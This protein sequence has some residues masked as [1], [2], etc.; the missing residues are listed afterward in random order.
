MATSIQNPSNTNIIVNEW[1]NVYNAGPVAGFT[2]T[3]RIVVEVGNGTTIKLNNNAT[4]VTAITQGYGNLYDGNATSIAFEGTLEQVNTALQSLQALNNNAAVSSTLQISAVKAGSAYNPANGHY[5]QVIDS[6]GGMSWL[7]AKTAAASDSLK[8]NGLTGYLA[9]ITSAQENEFILNKL[10]ADA[11]IGATDKDTEGRWKWDTGPEA[12]QEFWYWDDLN[13]KGVTVDGRYH[14]W[15]SN[16]PN[17]STSHTGSPEGEDYGQFYVSG[18]SPGKWND[19]PGAGATAGKLNYYVVEYGGMIGDNPTEAAASSSS[20]LTV[21]ARPVITSNGG[22]ATASINYA[23][24]GSTAV[25]TVTATDADNGDS[26]TYSITG[27]TDAALFNIENST[28]ALTFKTSPDYEGE[29]ENSY[30][31]TVRVTDST[32]LY[33]EQTL[34]V[35]VTDVNDHAPVFTSGVTGSVAENAAISTVIYDAATTDA[36]GTTT[37][38]NVVYSLKS[39]QGDDASLLDI[40]ST[41]GEVSLKTSA[42][43]E[44]KNSYAFT[45]VATNAGTGATLVTEQ[46]VS[47]SVSDVNDLPVITAGTNT[48]FTEQTP[49][50][51]APAITMNDEDAN[52][53]GG[54]LKAQITSNASADD[55]LILPTTNP[56]GSGIWLDVI[57]ENLLMSGATQ[58][59]TASASSVSSDTAWTFTFNNAA[60]NTLVQDVARAVQ[61]AN[62]SNEPSTASRTIT[63]SAKDGLADSSSVSAAQTV[64]ITAVN[65]A[66]QVSNRTDPAIV[67]SGEVSSYASFADASTGDNAS[68]TDIDASIV[69]S[70]AFTLETWVKFTDLEG[71]QFIA[72]K[73]FEQMELHTNGNALRFIP[74]GSAW[75][76]TGAVL[77]TGEWMHIAATYNAATDVSEIYINGVKVTTQDNNSTADAAL[78]DTAS[79]YQLGLRGGATSPLNGAIAEYR[80]WDDVRTAA[81]IR[82]NMSISLQGDEA[83]LVALWKLDES[84]GT[85]LQDS[86]ANNFDGTLNAG[87]WIT[88]P[89][90][91]GNA[92]TYIEDGTAVGLFSDVVVNTVESGQAISGMSF[93]VSNVSD[94][95]E[96]L[97]IDGKAIALTQGSTG[98]TTTTVM[99]YSVSVSDGTATVTLSKAGG[100]TPDAAAALINGITYSNSSQNPSTTNPRA[101]TLTSMT[102]SG[103]GDATV[104]LSLASTVTLVA[105]NDAP[106]GTDK[107]ITTLAEDG[108]HTFAAADFG[109][110]DT[111]DTMTDGPAANTLRAVNITTLPAK[112]SLTLGG[113]AVTEGQ[114][115]SVADINA[116]KL[117]YTPVANE[118]GTGYTSFTFQVQDDGGTANG[119]VDL[120]LDANTITLNVTPVNDAPVLVNATASAPVVTTIT[121]NATDSAGNLIS[122]LVRA[123]DGTTDAMGVTDK[124]FVTDVDFASKGTGE[125]YDG[126]VAIYGLSNDGPADGGKWQYKLGN[127]TWTDVGAV[128][129]TSA[130]L[131]ASTDSIRFVPDEKNATTA[132]FSYYLWDGALGSAGDKVNVS[133]RGTTTAFSTDGDVATI[134]VTPLNDA[135]TLDLD[136][137]N[138]STATGTDFT[139]VFRPLGQSVALVDSDV[140]IGD[141]DKRDS[142]GTQ[143]GT[144]PDT[145]TSA[146]VFIASGALN[147]LGTTKYETLS[148]TAGSSFTATSGEVISI[149]GNGISS[150]SP[151]TLTGAGTWADYQEALQTLR[152]QNTSDS[153]VAGNRTIS[154]TVTDAA[155]TTGNEADRLESAVA[156]STV[157]VIWAPVQ[158]LDGSEDGQGY[159]TTYVEDTAGIPI[160]ASDAVINSGEK[161]KSLVATLKNPLDGSSGDA[162]SLFIDT[163]TVT[164]LQDV[165]FSIAGNGTHTLTLTGDLDKSLY[166]L[167]LQAIQYK[168]TSQNPSTTAR[169]VEVSVTDVNNQTGAP[170]V[171]TVNITPVNDAPSDIALSDTAIALTDAVLDASSKATSAV[172]VATITVTDLDNSTHTLSVGGDDAALFEVVN[173]NLYLKAGTTLDATAKSSYAVSVTANDGSASNNTLTENFTIQV[174]E[175]VAPQFSIASVSGT[176]LTLYYQDSSRLDPSRVPDTSAFTVTASPPVAVSAVSIPNDTSK[177]VV[178]TLDTAPT[179]TVTVGYTTPETNPVQDTSGNMAASLNGVAVTT[180]TVTSGS[181]LTITT[182]NGGTVPAPLGDFT[183]VNKSTDLV[184]VT[185][186]TDGQAVT[187]SG[188]GN[189]NVQ[190]PA[191]DLTVDNNGTGTVTVD[192]LSAGKK[193]TVKGSGPTTISNPDGSLSVGNTG[194][195]LV[196]VTGDLGGDTLTI[197]G[198]GTGPVAI[199]NTG[200]TAVTV[201]SVNDGQTITTS[202]TGPTTISNPDGSLS[203]GNTGTGLV[204]VSG[205]L[206]GDTLT[207]DGAGTGPVTINNTGSTA[208][209]VASVN[210]GQ[211]ITASGTGPTTI[212]DPDGSLSVGNTGTGLVTVS[213]DLAGDTLTIDGAGTGPVAINNTGSTAVTVAS[214]NDGQTITASGTGPTTIS[215]PDGSLSVEN[216]GAGV[217]T[218]NGLNN[219]ATLTTSGTGA[220]HI[221]APDGNLTVA[222]SGTGTVTVKGL[223]EGKTL[224]ATGTQPITVDLSHLTS[225]QTI[226]IDNNGSGVVNL[227]NVPE[228]VTVQTTGSEGTGGINYAPTLSGIPSTEQGV[229]AG[230]AAALADFTVADKD[231][232][233]TLTITLTATNGTIG[234]LTDSDTSKAGIQL[235]GKAAAINNALAGATF[236]AASAGAA[237]IT[238]SVTDGVVS[239]PT[240][241]TYSLNAVPAPSSGSAP[242]PAPSPEGAIQNG[243]SNTTVTTDGGAQTTTTGTIGTVPVVETV[244]VTADGNT[245]RELVYVP[246]TTGTGAGSSTPTVLP[247]LYESV[248]GSTSNTTVSLPSGVGLVSVGDRTPTTTTGQQG[249]ITLI[250]S[251]VSDGDPSRTDML[252]G[253]QSFLDT[254]PQ[255]ATLWVNKIQ[256]TA[257]TA[258][259]NAPSVPVVVRGAINPEPDATVGNKLEALVIDATALPSGTVLELHDIDFAVIVGNGVIVRGGSG[260][261]VVYGGEGA[262]YILLGED[263]DVLYG[264]GGDDTVGSEGGNDRIFGNAGNDTLFGGDGADL[265]HGGADTDVATFT[266]SISRYEIVRD[267][268]KT[269]VRSLDRADDV[270]TVINVE[271]L[272][273]DDAD[274]AVENA[275]HYTV[276][277]SLY[278]EVLDR[279]ADLAGFQYWA[280]RYAAGESIGDIALSFLY[281]AEYQSGSGLQFSALSTAAQLDLFYLHFLGRTPDAAGHA[282]W[283]DRIED[284]MSLN[285]VAHS[286]V[287]STEMQGV[288]VQPTAWEFLL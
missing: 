74:T 144:Q 269:I 124:S 91:S 166:G 225:G 18:G 232:G 122:T 198:A 118:N 101:V 243:V 127:G 20:T 167:A 43:Y 76:D 248:A 68:P 152:Y 38:R 119:G 277:A 286:F 78:A 227:V 51:V 135:P 237:S 123:V 16:E 94:A 173:G 71:V 226:T 11:W 171:S 229:T 154:I 182:P 206:A 261:N 256:L 254:L 88:R 55:S 106:F 112:G 80:I 266:G 191:G 2:G 259:P 196:T 155:V 46:A 57:G 28:G 36:D 274:Y 116:N 95:T 23:E 258:L 58:I 148:S 223:L 209:T 212:N 82:D 249:L 164:T 265:L 168:N 85:A 81:E 273:F 210:D 217:V 194:T 56:G 267:H 117:V 14:N 216:T 27:G 31:V 271:T 159:T 222:N 200:S 107:T 54:T 97:N 22:G 131:L 145:L 61:F 186:A 178:L 187:V 287:V 1:T 21:Q 44:V 34:T 10:P 115:V 108:A 201:A 132:T 60:T 75:V 160:A 45:V 283:M 35:N 251:T 262:Q 66:P 133:T 151:L 161:V 41:T 29:G 278:G 205:D 270:D 156:T 48:A 162:E 250:Q 207:I 185:G 202:G 7:A 281:S 19:L 72:G 134:T 47:V 136:A 143:P 184:T 213:G 65:D 83:N 176:T 146:K 26:K 240:T 242:T 93:T 105:V 30:A 130:L 241:A 231:D 40:N 219:G 228:G 177:T 199:N 6:V 170:V 149:S 204:T 181:T 103:G 110:A 137:D 15:N 33:D 220:T 252:G 129:A 77:V 189:T 98:T 109:F 224:N 272:R 111:T 163:P 179:G 260:A 24:N 183:L 174:T 70:Q 114:M 84:P 218:V 138:S 192:G 42:N 268:G 17:N 113:T 64:T 169:T 69:A 275:P 150:A 203:V 180:A 208:V 247:L 233:A 99:G 121:E 197:D 234:G 67:L 188:T 276:I 90:A 39:G 280:E 25:T 53:D 142:T 50:A 253:G 288:Y 211:T 284:G 246:T 3:V 104:T 158:D 63:F 172:E 37:N 120:D 235:S 264:G 96:Y 4:G 263:D 100:L 126:G 12:G 125:G 165:G 147:N 92:V 59:G 190:S 89:V 49:T 32:G 230:S 52:W 193:L 140:Y 128:S 221:T 215:N 236:T 9:T 157:Q 102:D 8:F 73:G 257:P 285:D 175:A 279:Q 239:S 245:V 87:S 62:D 79:A 282:Y 153:A 255:D 86:T 5:Y 141:V 139:T 238:I 13:A 195:G 244:T 214:V